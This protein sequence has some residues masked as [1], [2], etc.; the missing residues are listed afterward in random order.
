M[1]SKSFEGPGEDEDAR[2]G[3]R[4]DARDGDIE[5]EGA[6]WSKS[7]V[8]FWSRSNCKLLYSKGAREVNSLPTSAN[9]GV[10]PLI[11]QTRSYTW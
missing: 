11:L 5:G 9:F 7:L 4:M 6:A 3:D 2:G 10:V 1:E 8:D